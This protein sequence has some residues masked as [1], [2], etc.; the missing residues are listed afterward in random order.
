VLDLNSQGNKNAAALV[1]GWNAW[2]DAKLPTELGK[3]QP[4]NVK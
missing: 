1:G 2:K 3:P 4:S